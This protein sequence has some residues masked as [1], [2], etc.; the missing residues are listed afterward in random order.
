MSWFS[1][2]AY[3]ESES[4][5]VESVP[6]KNNNIEYFKV[7]YCIV[8]KHFNYF[9]AID[10]TSTA[11]RLSKQPLALSISLWLSD[12]TDTL[13]RVSGW[14]LPSLFCTSS[15]KLRFVPTHAATL[16]S[17]FRPNPVH[18][19][20]EFFTIIILIFCVLQRWLCIY[21]SYN[22]LWSKDIVPLLSHSARSSLGGPVWPASEDQTPWAKTGHCPPPPN[23]NYQS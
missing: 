5:N 1:P 7:S 15:I 9:F 17:S 23:S 12:P 6:V 16:T 19:Q 21:H 3:S 20:I 22:L 18:K 14:R 2:T 8:V 13:P 11:V 10:D 4:S